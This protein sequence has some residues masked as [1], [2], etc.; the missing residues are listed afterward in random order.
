[1]PSDGTFPK[2]NSYLEKRKK[3]ISLTSIL[4]TKIKKL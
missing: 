3:I 2:S 4:K 1:M